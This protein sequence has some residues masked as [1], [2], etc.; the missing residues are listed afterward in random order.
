MSEWIKCSDRLPD[1]GRTILAYYLNSHGMGRTIR[2][3]HVKAWTIQ[4]EEFSDSE[5]ECVEYSEQ[6]D[7]YYLLA[8]WYECIDN[9]DEY[10]RVYVNEGPVTHW[11]PLP[12]PPK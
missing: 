7:A 10:M 1:S 3:Q 8:G 2:A 9:W 5:A 11:Q 6:E 12:E 4:A